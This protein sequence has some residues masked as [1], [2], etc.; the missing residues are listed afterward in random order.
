MAQ[1]WAVP[2]LL[3]LTAVTWKE[4]KWVEMI[5][6]NTKVHISLSKIFMCV[7]RPESI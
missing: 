6:M 2:G 4:L 3:H 5:E 7:F 1:I